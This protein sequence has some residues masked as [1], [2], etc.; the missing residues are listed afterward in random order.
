MPASA[1][2]FTSSGL[3]GVIAG[4]RMG[5]IMVHAGGNITRA[6]RVR[7]VRFGMAVGTY[8]LVGIATIL[9]CRLG[10]G[11]LSTN[12]WWFFAAFAFIGNAAFF[13]F[14]LTGFN[15]RFS[16]PSLTWAQIFYSTC[17]GMVA[18]YAL[19][20]ARPIVLMFYLPAFSFGMLS[21]K[22][23]QYMT[24]TGA[25]MALY[26]SLLVLEYL[27]KRAGFDFNYEIFLFV[28]FGILLLWVAS[29]G[30]F[31][32]GLRRC[33]AAQN[34]EIRE[35]HDRIR[36][37]MDERKKAEAEK[38]RVIAELRYTLS[39]VRAL[40]G[41]LP[42]CA[43]C[44]KIRDDKGYWNQIE[45]YISSHS[46]AEFSHGICPDCARKL[47]GDLYTEGDALQENN[48]CR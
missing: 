5:L 10:L 41:L 16:D 2:R 39:Q 20:G 1:N 42:I 25:V 40:K 21:L 8:A 47:Y 7:L 37:E 30:G 15:L 28:I 18:L 24:L 43:S 48:F 35:S 12:Q 6:Q 29:F 9:T 27:E 32:S 22:K 14:F 44:K 34:R 45:A 17:W 36:A 31:V 33:L 23:G 19:P 26:G 3:P 38:E 11:R 46:D 13:L 4:E